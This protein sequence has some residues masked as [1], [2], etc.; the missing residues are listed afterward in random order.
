MAAMKKAP[1]G[2]AKGKDMMSAIKDLLAA[3]LA[4]SRGSGMR[5]GAIPGGGVAPSPDSMMPG[6]GAMTQ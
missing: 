2:K 1:K 3:K 4:A 5:P 6:A